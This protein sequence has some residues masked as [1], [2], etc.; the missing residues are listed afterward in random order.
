MSKHTSLTLTPEQRQQLEATVHTG[1]HK[2]RALTRMRITL[3]LDRSQE[4]RY[5]DQE[6]A[7]ILGCDRLTVANTRRLPRRRHSRRAPRKTHGTQ[8]PRENDGRSRSPT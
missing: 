4:K 2:A 8:R 1:Q 7:E 5:T 3:L 6:I